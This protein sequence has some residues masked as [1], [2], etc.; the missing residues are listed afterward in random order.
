M[1]EYYS[2]DQIP[3]LSMS[4]E[5]LD[6]QEQTQFDANSGLL[7]LPNEIL[8]EMVKH[9]PPAH[10]TVQTGYSG[11]DDLHS[12]Q[13]GLHGLQA[14]CRVSRRM[15]DVAKPELYRTIV[16]S[17]PYKL[18]RLR[19]TLDKHPE[20]GERVRSLAVY[21]DFDESDDDDYIMKE[22]SEILVAVLLKTP[23]LLTL[24][25]NFDKT[26][27]FDNPRPF[28]LMKRSLETYISYAKQAKAPEQFLPKVKTL[29]ILLPEGE[30]SEVQRSE[31]YEI[32]KDLLNLP[33]LRHIVVRRPETDHSTGREMYGRLLCKLVSHRVCPESFGSAATRSCIPRYRVAQTI[34]SS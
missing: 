1:A 27:R 26:S 7:S 28:G 17:D 5:A 25:L 2:T 20:L 13:A 24:S 12:A 11:S 14:L 3:G 32:F 31:E 21:R 10:D 19:E 9:L 30:A 34:G 8:T 23:G 16:V 4:M 6:I 29:G 22:F 33:S 15:Q 18:H